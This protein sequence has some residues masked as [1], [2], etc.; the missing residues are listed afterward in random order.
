MITADA[1]WKSL[2][3]AFADFKNSAG[4][5]FMQNMAQSIMTMGQL[6]PSSGVQMGGIGESRYQAPGQ[7][8]SMSASEAASMMGGGIEDIGR[9]QLTTQKNIETGIKQVAFLLGRGL[10]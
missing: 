9:Q 10:I 1:Y 8:A 5:Q 6:V 4:M 3:G 2:S 7:A